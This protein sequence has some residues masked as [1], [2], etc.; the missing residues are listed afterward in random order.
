[1][2][3]QL[4]VS[5]LQTGSLYALVAL[6]LYVINK[7]TGVINFAQGEFVTLGALISAVTFASWKWSY[8]IAL[9]SSMVVVGLLAVIIQISSVRPLNRRGNDVLLMVMVMIAMMTVIQQLAKLVFGAEIKP[10]SSPL[11][12]QPIVF[13]GNSLFVLPH[14]IYIWIITTIVFVVIYL[15]YRF[16]R[17]GKLFR[18]VGIDREIAKVVGINIKFVDTTA[19][20]IGG[21]IGALGGVLLAPISGA[22]F[23]IGQN[24]TIYGFVA[25]VLGGVDRAEGALVG[26]LVLGIVQVLSAEYVSSI[27]ASGITLCLLLLMLLIR[28]QGL[29]GKK[30]G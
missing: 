28:P 4:A 25:L 21:A 24:M 3:V 7:S 5:G 30:G 1:M 19:F 13:G 12:G 16:T 2:L 14:T 27:F 23:L 18:A 17:I 8:P 9:I 11:S 15:F 22:H 10:V 6:G 20:L 26:G 29:L